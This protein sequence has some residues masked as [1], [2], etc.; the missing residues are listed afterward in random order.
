MHDGRLSWT[1][2]CSRAP[3]ELF[4]TDRSSATAALAALPERLEGVDS[5]IY[6]DFVAA[7]D[8][9]ATDAAA[10]AERLRA[11]IT[12]G[13]LGLAPIV[14]EHIADHLQV[15]DAWSDACFAL[16]AE[17]ATDDPVDCIG[18]PLEL[19][20][21]PASDVAVSIECMTGDRLSE[22][23]FDRSPFP[24]FQGPD[25]QD[26]ML[27]RVTIDN[28]S[29]DPAQLDPHFRIRYLDRDGRLIAELLWTEPGDAA[30]WV[31]P[32]TRLDQMNLR[33]SWGVLSPAVR[34][35][36]PTPEESAAVLAETATCEVVEP[37]TVVVTP[38]DPYI[39]DVP[40]EID[41]ID[42]EPRKRKVCT[43]SW[44]SSPI[45]RTD[46]SAST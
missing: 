40:V 16:S 12:E 11:A 7:T 24:F 22:L 14:R 10:V 25:D 9:L 28:R 46:R 43:S 38:P 31:P 13:Q 3:L 26:W 45:P 2:I 33:G 39:E 20:G 21:E 27:S 37:V 42:C 32:D 35:D 18:L 4:E 34:P 19:R 8:A 1:S 6:D 23:P 15:V 30:F 41:T 5:K 36:D 29:D 17:L 44:P